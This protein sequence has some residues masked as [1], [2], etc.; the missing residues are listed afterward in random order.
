MVDIRFRSIKIDGYRGR[1][2][3]L[4]MPK[5]EN[6]AVFVMENGT[7]KTTTIELL[8]WCFVYR[9]SEAVGKFQHMWHT[10]AHVLDW[11]VEHEQECVIEIEFE[12]TAGRHYKFE[13]RTVG[14]H[15]RSKATDELKGDKIKSIKDT[16]EIDRGKRII[17]GD[18]VNN[19][20]NREFKI[21]VSAPFFCFDGEKAREMIQMATSRVDEL[22]ELIRKR[23]THVR[24][25]SY[26]ESLQLVQKKLF[27][28]SEG[29]LSDSHGNKIMKMLEDMDSM[30]AHVDNEI[31]KTETRISVLKTEL[32]RTKGEI[33][34]VEA[35]AKAME[36]DSVRR[37]TELD[38]RRSEVKSQIDDAR[39]EIYEKC[40]QWM[41]FSSIGLVNDILNLVRERGKLPEPYYNDL[42][43]ACLVSP[44]TCQIC[45]RPL[46]SP[47]SLER[48]RRLERQIASHRVH[49]FLTTE[50]ASTESEMDLQEKRQEIRKNAKELSDIDKMIEAVSMTE[51]VKKVWGSREHLQKKYDKIKGELVKAEE[52]LRYLGLNRQNKIVARSDVYRK[53]K[54]YEENKPLLERIEKLQ[55]VLQ[56]A[57]EKMRERTIV[58]IGDVISKAVSNIIG[59]SFK[60]RLTPEDGLMLS[61]DGIFGQEV[62]GYAAQLVLSYLFAES[63]SQVGPIIIDTPAGNVSGYRASLA[64]HLVSNHPQVILLCLPTEL[65]DFAGFFSEN[66]VRKTNLRRL[67][68]EEN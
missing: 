32:D 54:T 26:I 39:N 59:D 50:L 66:A 2:F 9:E 57:H 30:L 67:N 10:T 5:K 13:R 62:G 52:N 24:L 53:S 20:M 19:F 29:K 33:N 31:S 14:T 45:G 65:D 44:P 11:L 51:E 7:G 21:G 55:N 22:V 49:I 60:A 47:E 23:T 34:T 16:L 36:S 42:I 1:H 37:R 46:D 12:D 3:M 40:Q 27:I 8:R 64:S 58:V 38:M 48:V 35:D 18:D 61:E 17:R 56:D 28:E 41:S 6:H 43:A 15:D 68:K 4:E 63:M 25:Q